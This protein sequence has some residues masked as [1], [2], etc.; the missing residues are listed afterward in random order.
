M[1]HDQETILQADCLIEI[2]PSAGINGGHVVEIGKPLT[3]AEKGLSGTSRYLSHGMT[4]PLRGKWRRLPPF[5][6]NKEKTYIE[7]SR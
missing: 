5:K 1:E 7:L 6:N 4:H 3:V 2:G